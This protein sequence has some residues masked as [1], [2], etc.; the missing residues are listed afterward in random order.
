ML[1]EILGGSMAEKKI[2]LKVMS[3]FPMVGGI[4]PDIGKKVRI[5]FHKYYQHK[6]NLGKNKMK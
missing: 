6:I 2:S 1:E 3:Y 4:I 5:D